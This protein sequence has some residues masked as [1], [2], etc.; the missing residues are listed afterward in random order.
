MQW[1]PVTD[2]LFI[3]RA[4][5]GGELSTQKAHLE[6]MEGDLATDFHD[7]NKRYTAQLVQVKACPV[8]ACL[9]NYY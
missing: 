1:L 4:R 7:I 2:I 5:L 8:G 6:G 3:Q 9:N